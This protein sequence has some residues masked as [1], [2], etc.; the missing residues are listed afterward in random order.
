MQAASSSWQPAR[1]WK[2]QSYTNFANKLKELE[3]CS[4]LEHSDESPAQLTSQY[5]TSM[6]LSREPSLPGLLTYRT[7]KWLTD[8]VLAATVVV[9]SSIPTEHGSA[10]W[11]TQQNATVQSGL[12]FFHVSSLSPDPP[13]PSL[14][15]AQPFLVPPFTGEKKRYSNRLVRQRPFLP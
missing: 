14:T 3:A 10:M 8:M 5:Q 13:T 11:N 9:I 15:R 7:V 2:Q 4:F 1:K 6:T 12:A